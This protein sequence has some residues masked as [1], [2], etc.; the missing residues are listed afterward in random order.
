MSAHPKVVELL[1]LLGCC[2][3]AVV[4]VVRAAAAILILLV[5]LAFVVAALNAPTPLWR[6][7]STI[8]DTAHGVT[9]TYCAD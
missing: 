1:A 6:C 7:A 9:H 4:F 3:E 8:S 2:V 5:A